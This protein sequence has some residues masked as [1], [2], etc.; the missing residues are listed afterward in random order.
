MARDTET[1]L[2][3]ATDIHGSDRCFRKFL[4][5]GKFYGA[6]I[7]LMG[8][9]IARAIGKPRATRAVGGANNKNPLAIVVPCH[10]VIGADGSL[11]GY[12]GGLDRKQWLLEH[13]ERHWPTD[14]S[15][16][17]AVPLVTHYK[18]EVPAT[19]AK[20]RALIEATL[21]H[22]GGRKPEAAAMLGIGLRTLYRKLYEI[23]HCHSVEAY[24]DGALVGGASLK[25]DEFL[26]IAKAA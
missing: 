14:T 19:A 2:F 9:D 17:K 18:I 24:Q 11:T 4:N 6:D 20:L 22:T 7:L 13:E 16:S 3:F 1:R 12:G 10:R 5:A 23:G 21:R 8:G 15:L 26:A 25:A